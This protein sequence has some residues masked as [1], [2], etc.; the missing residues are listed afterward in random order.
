MIALC[1]ESSAFTTDEKFPD[2]EEFQPILGKEGLEPHP[3][4]SASDRYVKE[5]PGYSK[6]IAL[7]RFD[8]DGRRYFVR[9]LNRDIG[10]S[11]L[12]AT[13][14]PSIFPPEIGQDKQKGYS[15]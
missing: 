14:D 4:L 12:S 2:M 15:R 13:D 6:V 8:L 11:Y 10:S 9:Y 7:V 5:L 3:D 1:G